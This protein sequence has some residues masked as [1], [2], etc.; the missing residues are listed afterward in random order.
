MPGDDC[1]VRRSQPTCDLLRSPPAHRVSPCHTRLELHT[2][3][4]FAWHHTPAPGQVFL[5]HHLGERAPRYRKHSGSPSKALIHPPAGTKVRPE[6]PLHRQG[7]ARRPGRGQARARLPP[8]NLPALHGSRAGDDRPVRILPDH[9]GSVHRAC[10]IRGIVKV[11]LV[12]C[13]VRLIES[14]ALA[15]RPKMEICS[16]LRGLEACD[17]ATVDGHES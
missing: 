13:S 15:A 1:C 12:S 16:M 3:C 7:V 14:R 4:M 11:C 10:E 17:E 2:F 6:E 5:R 8:Q 9:D